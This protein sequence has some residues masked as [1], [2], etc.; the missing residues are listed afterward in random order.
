MSTQ[1]T[2]Q[3]GH[4]HTTNMSAMRCDDFTQNFPI[5]AKQRHVRNNK[6]FNSAV[7]D[8]ILVKDIAKRNDITMDRVRQIILKVYQ[9][10]FSHK[11]GGCWKVSGIKKILSSDERLS[12][13]I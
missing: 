11:H 8:N 1:F 12:E 6:I 4:H 13:E 5:Q 3:L 10:Q 7:I 2:C 9:Q